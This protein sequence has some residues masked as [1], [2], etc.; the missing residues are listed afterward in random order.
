MEKN[1][2]QF[3][4]KKSKQAQIFILLLTICSFPILYY[5]LELPKMIVN[6]VLSSENFPTILYGHKV[7][8]IPYLLI[9]S[10]AFLGL[11]FIISYI[12]GKPLF[13]TLLVKYQDLLPEETRQQILKPEVIQFFKDYTVAGG[14]ALIA[15]GTTT[16]WAALK[17]SN[18]WWIAVRGIGFHLFLFLGVIGLIFFYQIRLLL[19]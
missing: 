1:I 12:I 9:L 5:T 2:Y 13:Y 7:D 8:Q 11:V 3:V 18:W 6:E 16:A 15:H 14:L 19:R 4:W 10:F 17:L